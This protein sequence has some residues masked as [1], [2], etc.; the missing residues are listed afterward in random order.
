MKSTT[1]ATVHFPHSH[2]TLLSH[3]NLIPA[4]SE[5]GNNAYGCVKQLYQLKKSNRHL[6]V[7]LSIGGWTYSSTFPAAASTPQSRATSAKTAVSFVKDWGL[8]G[9]DIDWEYPANPTEAADFV[10]LLKA[11]RAE[12]D[13]YSARSANNYH[14]LLT[15]ASPA[16]PDKYNTM[17]LAEMGRILDSF[18]L[19]AYDFA[20]SWDTNSGHQANLYHST[21]NPNATPFSADKAINDYIEKGVPADKIVLGM[22]IYGR[23]FE[24]TN[25]LGQ[26]FSGIGSGSWENG[27]WD[28]KVLP[29]AGATVQFDQESGATYSYDP[30]SKELISFDTVEMVQRKV[31]YVK[32]KGL[33]GSMFWEASADKTGAGSLLGASFDRLGGIDSTSN[34]LSYPESQYENIKRNLE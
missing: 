25:G 27:I 8:D 2:L 26:G 15:I 10:E 30:A 22:P 7:L 31:D 9:L 1:R 24:S 11:V 28:Y 18:N 20:G 29:K 4:W 16:G 34:L 33:G 23:A 13:A 17:Q 19:M 3:P 21:S 12:L 5:V 32:S 14:F 6:K